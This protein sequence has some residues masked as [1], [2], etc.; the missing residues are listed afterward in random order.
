MEPHIFQTIALFHRPENQRAIQLARKIALWLKQ[1]YPLI[2]FNDKKPEVVIVLGG[3]GTILEAARYYQKIQPILFGLNLGH[4]GFLSAARE[5]KNFLSALR[6]FWQGKFTISERMMLAAEVSRNGKAVAKV[7]AM[8]DI[9]VQNLLG[10]A[11]LEVGVEGHPFQYIHGSGV[12]VST[13]TGSTAYNLS[14]HG[15]IVMPNIECFIITE[16]LDHNIP[17][18]SLVISK[19]TVIKINIVNFRRRG[20]VSLTKNKRPVDVILIS[21]GENLFPLA[22][23]D[24]VTIRRSDHLIKFAELEK[25]YFFKSLQERFAFK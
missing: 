6:L 23:G 1:Q 18:P 8:N 3:D 20:L 19:E 13:A 21:D 17:T 10:M 15:P 22:K 25:H 4:V 9:S 24:V 16:L 5:P 12:L 7:E 2:E 11:E 14:A